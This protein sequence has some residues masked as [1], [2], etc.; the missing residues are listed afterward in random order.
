MS[1]PYA[2]VFDETVPGQIQRERTW[3]HNSR[4]LARADAFEAELRHALELIAAHPRMGDASPESEIDRHWLLRKS[5]VHAYYR[6]FDE[7]R[8]ILV[9]EVV[10][11]AWQAR[12][13]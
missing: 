3:I 6:V 7:S 12:R 10:P 9:V 5:R 1:E 13:W 8:E 4:G 2:V 11:E